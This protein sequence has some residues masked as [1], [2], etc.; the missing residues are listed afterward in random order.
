MSQEQRFQGWIKRND[1]RTVEIATHAVL[2]DGST[3]DV[4]VTNI[5]YDGC[6]IETGRTLP[7]G[8][9]LRLALPKLG[10]IE[11]Q[12]R[13]SLLGEAGIQFLLVDTVPDADRMRHV[14]RLA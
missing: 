11:A 2:S 8:E 13:W 12:V 14:A 6:R 4:R 5:S 1:R 9:G 3:V 10:E 7:I